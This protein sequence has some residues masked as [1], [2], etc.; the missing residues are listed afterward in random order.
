MIDHR[1]KIFNLPRPL[2]FLRG[3][4]NWAD[5]L[6]TNARC[7]SRRATT[8]ILSYQFLSLDLAMTLS[9]AFLKHARSSIV[10]LYRVRFG[11]SE[12]LFKQ[13]CTAY[14]RQ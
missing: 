9:S 11:E 10:S 13:V 6:Q 8:S 1:D 7:P 3:K 14:N 5:I 2:P 4:F 12:I